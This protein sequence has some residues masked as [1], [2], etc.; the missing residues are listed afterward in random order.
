MVASKCNVVIRIKITAHRATN[1][2][3]KIIS[4]T[5]YLHTIYDITNL[6]VYTERPI[7]Y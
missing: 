2:I 7:S 5:L 1:S 6:N 4:I 3:K